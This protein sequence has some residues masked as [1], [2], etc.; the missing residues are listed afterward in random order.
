MSSNNFFEK[1]NPIGDYLLNKEIGSGG[2]AKVFEATHIPTGEKVAVKIMDKAQIFAEPLNLNRIQR[3]IAI[4]KIVRHNNII[5]LYELMETADK[6]YIVMEYCNGGELFDYIVSKQHLTERQ[7]C[8]FFQEI[9]NCLEYLHSLN[10]VHRDIKPE[11]LLLYKIKNK[12]N[13]KLIDFGISNCYTMDKLLTTPCGTASYAPPEMHKGEEYYGLLSDIWSAGVVL[14]AMIF[15][16]LPF[17]EDDEDVN[18]NNIIEGNY[19]IPE[20]ASPEL[21]DLL[22][23][24]LDINPLT[25]YDLDQIKEHPWF[26]MVKHYKYIPGIIEG[27]NK[28]PVDMKIVN[29]CEHYGYD[30]NSVIENVKKCNYNRNSAVYYIILSKMKREGYHSISDLYSD[31]FL[32]YINNP[33]NYIV[34]ETNREIVD[35]KK[36]SNPTIENNITR[37]Q[38]QPV[39]DNKAIKEKD[40][41]I[42][43]N[44]EIINNKKEIQKS[45]QKN[46]S[47]NKT[48]KS[49]SKR[50]KEIKNQKKSNNNNNNIKINEKENVKNNQNSNQLT[51][52]KSKN[53]KKEN[54]AKEKFKPIKSVPK[55]N[56]NSLSQSKRTIPKEKQ[57]QK[58]NNK[59]DKKIVPKIK[60]DLTEIQKMYKNPAIKTEV[61]DNN[62]KNIANA[63]MPICSFHLTSKTRKVLNS[64]NNNEDINIDF[65]NTSFNKKL[66][67]DIKE[68]ILKL[69]NPKK[70]LPPK[71][72]EKKINNALLSLKMK[73]RRKKRYNKNKK[74]KLGFK[75]NIFKENNPNKQ[76]TIIHN[77]NASLAIE[78]K[79][80]N[81][82]NLSKDWVENKGM[83]NRNDFSYSPNIRQRPESNERRNIIN[84]YVQNK[85]NINSNNVYNI[86]LITKNNYTMEKSIDSKNRN[87]NIKVKKIKKSNNNIKAIQKKEPINSNHYL[88]TTNISNISF[89]NMNL[90][91]D[92]QTINKSQYMFID[93]PH[94]ILSTEHK[95]RAQSQKS[96]NNKNNNIKNSQNNL[97][98]ISF[99]NNTKKKNKIRL[100]FKSMEENN[101][102]DLSFSKKI[103]KKPKK[104]INNNN[105]YHHHK[106]RSLM[107]IDNPNNINLYKNL[108]NYTITE[109]KKSENNLSIKCVSFR[110]VNNRNIRNNNSIKQRKKIN[111]SFINLPTVSSDSKNNKKIEPKK[112]KG[113]ID[114]K[115]ILYSNDIN[116][117]IEK[118]GNTLKRNK[119]NVI[120]ISLHKLRCTKNGQSYDLEF[121]GLNDNTNNIKHNNIDNNNDNSNNN[122]YLYDNESNLKTISGYSSHKMGKNNFNIYYYTISSKV[123]NNKKLM[124][125]ISKIIYSKF[126][127]NKNIKSEYI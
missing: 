99:N 65:L 8:R 119:M 111:L 122:S 88:N 79:N 54:E 49:V 69:K 56:N 123:C 6:I 21:A 3:E 59:A 26:N 87:N 73:K 33:N 107:D 28:I 66:S 14:Y 46:K 5:K 53:I 100:T 51:S 55:K 109:N 12:I 13:L 29:L 118:I 94:N 113:P 19:E 124:K 4:L 82:K 41:T 70:N 81:N 86:N 83:Y 77:R 110:N 62:N 30:K 120:Y 61:I 97:N 38:S 40:K 127:L 52:R 37:H 27:Y 74:I 25:R 98:N 7:A 90:K 9:I 105:R 44:K 67:D 11:N 71:E 23:H 93:K 63:I 121:F 104:I 2:F 35:D 47:T 60:V 101:L 85:N 68:K 115:C 96:N 24:L 112:Y 64:M 91:N 45:H 10:I 75:A 116:T 58:I 57:K 48:P 84:I 31:E 15:G 80:I 72:K 125:I 92:F 103:D 95:N 106:S 108:N 114:L 16:Y 126:N 1:E 32:K 36:S 18:I 34:D 20:E 78:N 117:L 76:H 42:K 17:C 50:S 39:N 22:M 102:N 43:N 89:S